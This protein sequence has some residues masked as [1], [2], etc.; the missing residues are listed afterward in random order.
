MLTGSIIVV[1]VLVIVCMMIGIKKQMKDKRKPGSFPLE[2]FYD[3]NDKLTAGLPSGANIYLKQRVTDQIRW[4]NKSA[5]RNKRN[6]NRCKIT[7]L[8]CSALIPFVAASDRICGEWER[9]I[10]F[11]TGLL[12]VIIVVVSGVAELCKYQ[13][14][15]IYC[16]RT[17]EKLKTE[18]MHFVTCADKYVAE[19]ENGKSRLQ[20]FVEN[21]EG[22]I[23]SENRLWKNYIVEQKVAEK[24][25]IETDNA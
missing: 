16:R 2:N 17:A 15:R 1:L 11:V 14:R 22:I 8:V 12:G 18:V 6:Y 4:Y 13:E 25:K 20:R 5:K 9:Y 21:F 7:I 19:T 23:D 24:E 3:E 10:P